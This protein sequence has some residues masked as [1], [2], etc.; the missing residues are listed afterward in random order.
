MLFQR[1]PITKEKQISALKQ[2]VKLW[3]SGK[4][5]RAVELYKRYGI[6]DAQFSKALIIYNR[7]GT[8]E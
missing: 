4:P 6:T 7:S 8:S 3:N 1:K 5:K 2:A